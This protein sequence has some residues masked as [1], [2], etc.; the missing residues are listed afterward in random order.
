[1]NEQTRNIFLGAGAGIIVGIIV[2]ASV[3]SA[4]ISQLKAEGRWGR[5][6][7]ETEKKSAALEKELSTLAESHSLVPYRPAPVP[8]SAEP[9][10]DLNKVYTFEVGPTPVLG[11]ANAPVAITMF[12]DFQCPFC[13]SSYGPVKEA[14]DAYPGKVRFMIKNFPLDFHQNAR[15]AAK[16][17]L[18]ADLQGKYFEMVDLIMKNKAQASEDK[19]KEYAKTLGLDEKKLLES[20]KAKDAEFE[21]QIKV[22]MSLG[23][24]CD[25]QGT[26]TFFLNG[27]KTRAYDLNSWKAEIDKILNSK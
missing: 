12:A 11:E 5:K 26:P 2:I 8:Y 6:F 23:E 21:K 24:R 25:V 18:A 7:D 19:L 22:D 15:P 3:V 4:G 14:L 20:L 16:A 10:E 9:G 13:A 1:M 27:K 17:A